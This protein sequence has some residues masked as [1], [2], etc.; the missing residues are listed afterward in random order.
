M[1]KDWQDKIAVEND[2]ILTENASARG[3][4]E[5]DSTRFDDFRYGSHFSKAEE[6]ELL[7]F[8][9]APLPISITT[10]ICD[11]AE[12]LMT[13]SKP[14]IKVA[15]IIHPYDDNLTD[16]SKKVAAK[17]NYLVQKSW[18]DSLGDLQFDRVVRDYTNVG[19][20][21]FYVVPKNYYG[22]FS[23]EI[24]HINWRY[25]YPDCYTKDPF[26]RDMDN[27]CIAMEISEK[28]AYRF[29]KQ[30]E[31]E[32]TFEGFK[33][34]WLKKN[35]QLTINRYRTRYSPRYKSTG[36][37]FNTR[38]QLEEHKAYIAIYKKSDSV[39]RQE[40]KT[41]MK[42]S[43]ELIK[44]AREGY[45]EIRERKEFFLTEYVSIGGLGYKNVYP[46]K[47]YNIIPM[48]YDHRDNPYPYGRIWYLYPI[49]RAINK[50]VMVAMLNGAMI[51]YT[52]ILSEKGS[53]KDK[54][55]FMNNIFKPGAN[56]EWEQTIPGV[57]KPPVVVEGKPLS[58][59]WLQFP[60][61]LSYIMEY[62]SGIFGVMMGDSRESP[63]VFSTVATL[64][65]AGSQ[66]MKRR[67]AQAD[68][69]LSVVGKVV[70][71]FYKEYAPING[72]ATIID[73]L[74][75]QIDPIKYNVLQVNPK[76]NKVEIDPVTDLSYG[77]KDV[78]FTT[79][80]SNGYESGTEAALL[81][82]L[83]T[84][85]KVPQL[86][87]LILKRL[88]IPDIDKILANMDTVAQLEQT[89]KQLDATV[90]EL[91][92]KTKVMAGQIMQKGFETSKAQFDAKFTKLLER[93]K[94][95]PELFNQLMLITEEGA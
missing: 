64:Q 62:V 5:R 47:C 46:V 45:V 55:E 94:S 24:K 19:H 58:D 13:S 44:L 89:I 41:Y 65:S 91:D 4:W 90:K 22:E 71:E 38:Y 77:F 25:F 78:R 29:V 49:Q 95:D 53:I 16:I 34:N 43:E 28:A 21:L 63:N 54:H 3:P 1:S 50:F 85:L 7:A 61:Y 52:R 39:G 75:E 76:T 80:A 66:K 10:A 15:P 56:I 93:A 83:A 48:V 18:N 17:Y 20:G 27:C 31:R 79:Q 60:K 70:G 87:P 35:S 73:E 8:R 37:I 26:Y 86:V 2:K 68:A 69:S 40:V 84:Q 59:A 72:Y 6:A 67:L 30:Y 74:G 57:T 14:I 42:L 33:E 92:R 36:V 32:L 82:N 88:N 81:T 11:T 51:N 23:V 12:S 9:Q